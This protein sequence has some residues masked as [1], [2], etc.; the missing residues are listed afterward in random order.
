MCQQSISQANDPN[1]ILDWIR[2]LAPIPDPSNGGAPQFP[3]AHYGASLYQLLMHHLTRTLPSEFK[4]FAT[5]HNNNVRQPNTTLVVPPPNKATSPA[6]TDGSQKLITIYA[7]LPLPV[8]KSIIESA[9]FPPSDMERVRI[10]PCVKRSND[11]TDL[12]CACKQFAFAKKCIAERK[13]VQGP[14]STTTETAVLAFG[15]DPN[16]ASNV[17]IVAKGRKGRQLWK[18]GE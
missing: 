8:F 1:A 2:F 18:A 4:A 9:D 13:R 6:S 11:L 10:C 3:Y 14:G 16:K 12:Y 5:H 15:Q 17:E 7:I